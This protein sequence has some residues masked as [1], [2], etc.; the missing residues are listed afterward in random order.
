MLGTSTIAEDLILADS[1]D[2][3]PAPNMAPSSKETSY[4]YLLEYKVLSP[5]SQS[6]DSNMS[7]L[8]ESQ[9]FA[10]TNLK[11]NSGFISSQLTV[12]CGARTSVSGLALVFIF[13]G[14]MIIRS[15]TGVW[16]FTELSFVPAWDSP[17]EENQESLDKSERRKWKVSLKLNIQKTKIIASNSTTYPFHGK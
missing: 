13:G 16:E 6:E 15:Q 1:E 3:S 2:A 4:H 17:V 9:T 7:S 12:F 11:G 8:E 5:F 10:H 14:S